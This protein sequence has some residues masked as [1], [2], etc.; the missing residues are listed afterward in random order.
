M[1][2]HRMSFWSCSG[3]FAFDTLCTAKKVAKRMSGKGGAVVP[4][5]CTDCQAWRVGGQTQRR[6]PKR[7]GSASTGARW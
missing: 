6:R 1:A 2:K 4:Y 7:K 3:K 5:R